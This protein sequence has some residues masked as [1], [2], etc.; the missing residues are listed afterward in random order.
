MLKETKYTHGFK[1]QGKTHNHV[2]TEKKTNRLHNVTQ[3]E[4]DYAAAW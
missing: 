1:I 3:N 2:T 4:T